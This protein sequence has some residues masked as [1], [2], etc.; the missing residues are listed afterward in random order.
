MI[1]P[2]REQFTIP[3]RLLASVCVEPMPLDSLRELGGLV[4]PSAKIIDGSVGAGERPLR[5]VKLGYERT[6]GLLAGRPQLVL[7]GSPLPGAEAAAL[8]SLPPMA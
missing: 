1:A 6:R 2:C 4:D 3:V 5:Q 8:R 7:A